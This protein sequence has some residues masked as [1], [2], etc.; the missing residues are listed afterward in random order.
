MDIFWPSCFPVLCCCHCFGDLFCCYYRML[1]SVQ[2][3]QS[4]SSVYPWDVWIVLPFLTPRWK[5]FLHLGLT[6]WLTTFRPVFVEWWLFW[7]KVSSISEI[8]VTGLYSACV[9]TLLSILCM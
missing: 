7:F 2:C 6:W 4:S 9:S 1:H 5:P 3:D 8:W